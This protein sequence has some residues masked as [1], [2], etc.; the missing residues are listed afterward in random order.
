LGIVPGDGTEVLQRC[1]GYTYEQGELRVRVGE[2]R[3][4]KEMDRCPVRATLLSQVDNLY[5]GL[6]KGNPKRTL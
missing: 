4:G 2:K 5:L 3:G 1:G 6:A